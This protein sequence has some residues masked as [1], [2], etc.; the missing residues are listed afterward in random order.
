MDLQRELGPAVQIK[1]ELT[2]M[3]AKGVEL[4]QCKRELEKGSDRADQ[5]L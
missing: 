4:Q 5:V 3:R 1:K 2:R